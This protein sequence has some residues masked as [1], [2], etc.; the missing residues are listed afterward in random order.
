GHSH[1]KNIMR[2]KG[3]Q[4]AAKG[5]IFTKLAREIIVSAKL[6]G[7]DPAYNARLRAAI[8]AARAENMTR[9]RIENAIKKG[10]GEI[11]SENYDEIRY[12]GYA[13][14]GVALIVEALTDNK[15]RT[16]SNV[17]AMFTKYGG[18]LGETGSVAFM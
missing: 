5:K 11:E 16:A 10:S 8:A 17:R 4:D 2:H 12:E 1:F 15:N 13:G 6:G 7:G 9:D 3:K 14:D 18:N